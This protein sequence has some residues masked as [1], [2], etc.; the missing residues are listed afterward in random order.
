LKRIVISFVIITTFLAGLIVGLLIGYN[1]AGVAVHDGQIVN[2]EVF[3][4]EKCILPEGFVCMD[5][6]GS[7]TGVLMVIQNKAGF[8]VRDLK[9]KVNFPP[10]EIVCTDS[11]GDSELISGEMETFTC[12]GP[13]YYGQHKGTLTFDYLNTETGLTHSKSGEIIVDVSLEKVDSPLAQT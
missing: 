6:E 10:E 2:E 5:F 7:E 8:D 11:A 13:L 9:V 12:T 4:P 1:S 3:Y